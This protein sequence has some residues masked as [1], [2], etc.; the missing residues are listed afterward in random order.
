MQKNSVLSKTPPAIKKSPYFSGSQ[1]APSKSGPSLKLSRPSFAS[2]Q[3]WATDNSGSVLA[4][5]DVK[6]TP[7]SSARSG[8]DE[9]TLSSFKLGGEVHAQ[10]TQS[11]KGASYSQATPNVAVRALKLDVT[12]SSPANP[13]CIGKRLQ[14]ND[15]AIVSLTTRF[16]NESTST[17]TKTDETFSLENSVPDHLSALGND[18]IEGTV[19]VLGEPPK[20]GPRKRRL[21]K[22]VDKIPD[23]NGA[24]YVVEKSEGLGKKRTRKAVVRDV[25]NSTETSERK[26]T[27]HGHDEICK[28]ETWEE[29]FAA[30]ANRSP[31]ESLT[32]MPLNF[33]AALN[34]LEE[35]A[36]K[37]QILHVEKISSR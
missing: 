23:D 19:Q 25:K 16:N 14:E 37:G 20:N 29:D 17:K 5:C 3:K 8:K 4:R 32:A 13:V 11:G 22:S 34:A 18:V 35:V 33:T 30:F 7:I 24:S 36:S 10:T 21:C 31:T 15:S 2:S 26:G 28:E 1:S 27:M 9:H 12:G 6:S